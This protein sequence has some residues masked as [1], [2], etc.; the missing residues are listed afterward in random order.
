[1]QENPV[2]YYTS[3]DGT[4]LL[5]F[6]AGP[7]MQC[8]TGNALAQ[9]DVFLAENSNRYLFS[10]LA[11]D[12]KNE[13]EDLESKHVSGA[14]LPDLVCWNP[15]YVISID[16]ETS[17][18]LQGTTDSYAE[19]FLADFRTRISKTDNA[20]PQVMFQPRLPKSEYLEHVVA[21]Q[22]EIQQ[23]NTYEMNFCQEFYAENVPEF[24]AWSLV[25]Q[26]NQ[27]T[28]APFAGFMSFGHYQVFCGSPERY[29]QKTGSR[30]ISQPIKGTIRRGAGPE[31]DELLKNILKNDPKERAEN[32]MIADLVR[33]DL[34]RIAQ[35]GS[36]AVDELCGIYSFQTVHHMIST[37]SCNLRPETSFSDIL[38]AT[39]PMGS[40]TGAPKISTMQLIEKHESFKRGLYAGSMGYFKPGGDF[41]FN[42][43]IRSFIHNTAEKYMSCAVGGAITIQAVAEK[44]YD[45]CMVKV[46]RIVQ[47]FGH[48]QPF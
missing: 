1:M 17:T 39:F 5:A 15:A 32:I 38:R 36:V 18:F 16:G 30:L 23:G 21:I 14:Q 26:L 22:Q 41:D 9:L 13:I 2:A 4:G 24:D 25:N 11:Y 44:E 29:M 7:F 10:W 42:V 8:T 40:M 12:L 3:N 19:Q 48:D 47:L 33:N 20:L 45:E 34:S 46:K 35:K 6:G 27:L 43:V 28:A 31:E 37:I